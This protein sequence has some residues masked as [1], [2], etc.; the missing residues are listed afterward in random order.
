VY[1]GREGGLNPMYFVPSRMR[2][3][4][5]VLL[6]TVFSLPAFSQMKDVADLQRF[7]NEQLP[8]LE[9][10]KGLSGYVS[11]LT[12]TD[13]D[14][15]T[16]YNEILRAKAIEAG[17]EFFQ[18]EYVINQG[19]I[20]STLGQSA[21]AV[22]LMEGGIRRQEAID[23]IPA[24]AYVNVSTRLTDLGQNNKAVDYLMKGARYFRNKGDSLR[25][26]VAY[27]NLGGVH[28]DL[29]D[30][31]SAARYIERSVRIFRNLN[32]PYLVTALNNMGGIMQRQKKYPESLR[33]F[34]QALI[35]HQ[36]RE[37]VQ[38]QALVYSNLGVV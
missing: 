16:Y 3:A 5:I 25:L 37:N 33:Y 13:P 34:K 15:A 28:Y 30:F 38:G 29:E 22:Q 36:V 18:A 1:Y 20:K 6:L 14:S 24:A 27:I 19:L 8:L 9:R 7:R 35:L 23:S 31:N 26:A 10:L 12:Q 2:I 21:L 4:L 11:S 17:S 32:H